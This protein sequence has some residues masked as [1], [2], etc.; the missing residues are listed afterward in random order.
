MAKEQN[1]RLLEQQQ[2]GVTDS[3]GGNG[4]NLGMPR[5]RGQVPVWKGTNRKHYWRE[6]RE[7]QTERGIK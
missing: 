4:G 1:R 5:A 2:S 3:M 6:D 7:R